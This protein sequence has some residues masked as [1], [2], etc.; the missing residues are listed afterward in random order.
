MYTTGPVAPANVLGIRRKLTRERERLLAEALVR[1]REQLTLV[2]KTLE[3]VV[4]AGPWTVATPA[5]RP[6]VV[7]RQPDERTLERVEPGDRGGVQAVC[8]RPVAAGLQIAVEDGERGIA[9]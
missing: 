9:C 6:V 7:A 1:R 4:T 2:R 5:V 8:A 3:R